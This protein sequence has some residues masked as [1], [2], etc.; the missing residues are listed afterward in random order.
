MDISRA[1][2]PFNFK[3][4]NQLDIMFFRNFFEYYLLVLFDGPLTQ[5]PYD[6]GKEVEGNE[7][8]GLRNNLPLCI[9]KKIYEK[10]ITEIFSTLTQNFLKIISKIFKISVLQLDQFHF[11]STRPPGNFRNPNLFPSLIARKNYGNSG[12]IWKFNFI[13]STDVNRFGFSLFRE[14]SAKFVRKVLYFCWVGGR[15]LEGFRWSKTSWRVA[16]NCHF[17]KI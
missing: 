5:H 15:G 11:Q 8:K 10:K 14:Y 13:P 6:Y 9:Q 7:L 16:L 2:S 17:R 3:N 1:S 4:G 12:K